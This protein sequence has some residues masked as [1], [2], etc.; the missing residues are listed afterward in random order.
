MNIEMDSFEALIERKHEAR[1]R[2]EDKTHARLE[3]LEAKA[4]ARIGELANGTLYF[5]PAGG[6]L[7]TGSRPNLIDFIIRNNYV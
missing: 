1:V 3:K 2:R 6:K 7:R 4:E 5:F